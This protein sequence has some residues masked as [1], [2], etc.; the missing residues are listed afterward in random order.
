MLKLLFFNQAPYSG[1]FDH[2]D[3]TYI[4]LPNG[5]NMMIDIS[6]KKSGAVITKQL[7]DRGVN[8]IDY[9]VA[10]HL[11]NDHTAGFTALSEHI[12]VRQ[13][14]MSGYGTNS[15]EADRSF[16][17]TAR[18]KQISV[19][20]FRL[21]DQLDLGEVELQCLFPPPDIAEASPDLPYVEQELN[22]NLYSMVFRLSY[23][24]FSVLFAGD[25][26]EATEQQLIQLHGDSLRSTL[27]KI[28]HHGCDTSSSQA[29]LERVNPRAAVVMCRSCEWPVQRRLSNTDIPVY[30]PLCDG[31][32]ALETDGKNVRVICDKGSREFLLSM[33]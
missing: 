33:I 15:V 1:V 28:P 12:S 10:S 27:L 9:F 29:L 17:E 5:Q 22:S 11:H 24:E 31:N 4:E 19:R 26:Y 20:E 16:L 6:T 8:T 21:G 14:L 23:G 13:I 18:A 30:N 2:G 3:S 32:V 25:I 7:L